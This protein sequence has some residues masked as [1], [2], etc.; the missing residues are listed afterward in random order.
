MTIAVR[1]HTWKTDILGS[2]LNNEIVEQKHTILNNGNSWAH[3]ICTILVENRGVVDDIVNIPLAWLAHSI[4][5]RH[6]L[7]VDATRLTIGVGL[8]VVVIQNLHLVLILQE[9]TAI[10]SSLA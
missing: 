10:A 5:Q 3:A 8:V 9:Y 6:H 1:H 2:T 7:L 4:C